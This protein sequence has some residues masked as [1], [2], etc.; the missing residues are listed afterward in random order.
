MTKTQKLELLALLEEKRARQ[1]RNNIIDYAKHIII[2]GAPLTDD[3]DCEQFYPDNVIPAK[4]HEVLLKTLQDLAEGKLIHNDKVVKNVIILAPPGSAKSTYASVVFPTWFMGDFPN[5]NIIMTTYGSDLAKK[6]GRKCRAV[7]SS[8]EFKEIF[9]TEITQGNSAADDWSITN[10]STYMSGGILSGITGNRADGLIID[11]PFKGR[12]EADSETIRN[13]TKEAYKSDLLTRLKPKGWKV[14]INTRWH[15]E[16]LCGDI[17]PNDY[18]GDSGFFEAK[19]G[20]IWKVLNFQAQCQSKTD[21]IGRKIGQFLWIDWFPIDWWEQTK[22]THAGY[23]WSALFQGVPTPDEGSFFL[24]KWFKRYRIGDQPTRLNKYIS[25]DFAVSVDKGDFSE[26]GVAGFDEND[27]LWILDWWSGQTNPDVWI[28]E[29]IKLVKKHNP[30]VSVAEGG[31]IR[32]AVEAFL[33]KEMKR[34]RCWFRQEWLVSNQNKAAN[35]RSFQGLA[36]QGKVWIPNCAWGDELIDQLIG[37]PH[38]KFDDKVDACGLFGRILD[39]TFAPS[40][41]IVDKENKNND[42]GLPDDEDENNWK[43]N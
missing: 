31:I 38:G 35:A 40:K 32:R 22:R 23:S 37:F 19:D 15:E 27:D 2:P 30:L 21:P 14:I 20:S 34:Q 9:D 24:R 5:S 7:S 11:D 39:Q 17:L 12:D 33:K 42:Y 1:S 36:S 10:Q 41:I 28:D 16:D 26:E 8:K 3:E 6:F 25:S 13:K 18:K 29:L 43:V 4:H